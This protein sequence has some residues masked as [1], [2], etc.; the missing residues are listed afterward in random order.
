VQ[1]QLDQIAKLKTMRDIREAL[2]NL[3]EGLHET[4]ENILGKVAPGCIDI[5]R[6]TLQWLVCDVST[7]TLAELHE[8]LA[9]E[10]GMDHIDEEAQLSSPMDIYDLCGSLIAITAE[11]EVIL[12][13]LSVKDYLLSDAI[14]HGKASAFALSLPEVNAE[15]SFKCLTYLSF[16]EFQTGPAP[17]ADDFE[18][19]LLAHPFLEHAS[20]WWATYAKNTGYSSVELQ[21]R[22]MSF[23]A[24]SSRPQFMSWLQ[25]ICSQVVLRAQDLKRTAIKKQKRRF[26]YYP[27]HATSLYYAASFGIEHVVKGLLEEGAEIDGT[28]GRLG[29]TAFHAAALRGHVKVM[30]I[31]FQKG[32]DPNKVDFINQTA[33]QSAALVNN[34]EV[35]KYLLEHGANPLARDDRRKTPYDWACI[36]G[37][38]EAQ[39]LLRP[40]TV[41]EDEQ[42][43]GSPDNSL[44]D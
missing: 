20:R 36:L 18:S 6:Q 24:S 5:V 34:P 17:T 30:N 27:K 39:N 16:K 32:A 41:V 33:L 26:Y 37:H 25:V 28:G 10:E 13:H 31:L 7:M 14:K 42:Q 2:N 9:I 40:V 15:N 8:C 11:G 22:V 1:C 29:A 44:S 19:R 21:N 4:Y 38:V 43:G 23:F 3:P 12:A 35:I